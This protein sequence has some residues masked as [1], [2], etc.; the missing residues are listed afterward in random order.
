MKRV[1]L[2][3]LFTTG[4]V[5]RPRSSWVHAWLPESRLFHFSCLIYARSHVVCIYLN[6]VDFSRILWIFFILGFI[7]QYKHQWIV[8]GGDIPNFKIGYRE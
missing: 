4:A 3:S 8:I 6:N 2:R 7:K 5:K 1:F